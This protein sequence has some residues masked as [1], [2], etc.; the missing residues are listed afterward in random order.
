MPIR[1]GLG[2]DLPDGKSA[3]AWAACRNTLP[4]FV[5]SFTGTHAPSA[6]T[7]TGWD[8]RARTRTSATSGIAE[9]EDADLAKLHATGRRGLRLRLIR[10]ASPDLRGLANALCISKNGN[11]SIRNARRGHSHHPDPAAQGPRRLHAHERAHQALSGPRAVRRCRLKSDSAEII[12]S[13]CSRIWLHHRKLLI[14][15]DTFSHI[16]TRPASPFRW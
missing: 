13:S 8:D 7:V 1:S 3:E 5:M 15:T 9:C 14:S 12:E 10:P 4:P 11:G 2:L 6:S 16:Q